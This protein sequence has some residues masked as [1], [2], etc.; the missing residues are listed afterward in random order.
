MTF[1]SYS[2]LILNSR[3]GTL[4]I[5]SGIPSQAI[6]LVAVPETTA[7]SFEAAVFLTAALRFRVTVAFLSVDDVLRELPSPCD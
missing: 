5:D 3:A 6:H 2:A 7:P 1:S 4:K